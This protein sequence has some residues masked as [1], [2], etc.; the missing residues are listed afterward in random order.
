MA[1]VHGLYGDELVIVATGTRKTVT[2]SSPLLGW[3][4]D[5]PDRL[6]AELKARGFDPHQDAE[7]SGN[8][9]QR[10]PVNGQTELFA[11]RTTIFWTVVVL[12]LISILEILTHR[13][14]RLVFHSIITVLFAHP[15]ANATRT[16]NR[17]DISETAITLRQ[18]S[19]QGFLAAFRP[20][21][22][23][24]E[25]TAWTMNWTSLRRVRLGRREGQGPDLWLELET[26]YSRP[27]LPY[28]GANGSIDR[29]DALRRVFN[30]HGFPV[31]LV[32]WPD[33]AKDESRDR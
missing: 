3:T 30:A 12:A 27:T 32:L 6:F 13:W 31:E 29:A 1:L 5:E 9:I 15:L 33:S 24:E 20:H 25:K 2:I 7:A 17:L 21:P 22:Q 23:L 26:D 28:R 8:G 4:L 19:P 16:A 10:F 11:A 18:I 14:D